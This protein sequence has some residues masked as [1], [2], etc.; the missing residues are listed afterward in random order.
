MLT[1]ANCVKMEGVRREG[2]THSCLMQ[3]CVHEGLYAEARIVFE[4]MVAMGIHLDRQALDDLMQ[5]GVTTPRHASSSPALPP[6]LFLSADEPF[7]LAARHRPLA[8]SNRAIYPV[9]RR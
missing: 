5:V 3:V 2:T 9:S 7:F 6:A 8:P 4:D 1:I